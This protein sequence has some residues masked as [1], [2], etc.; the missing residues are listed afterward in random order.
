[1]SNDSAALLELERWRLKAMNDSNP[2]ALLELL[3]DDHVHVLA[4]GF[5][6][7]KAGAARASDRS[8]GKSSRANP[9]Y[10]FMATPQ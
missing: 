3:G 9:R 5:V 6:T 1:M 8:P 10:E 7:D 2:V 4:N